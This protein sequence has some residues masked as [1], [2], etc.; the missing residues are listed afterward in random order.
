[1]LARP[2]EIVSNRHRFRG[3]N[4]TNPDGADRHR[5]NGILGKAKK[6]PTARCV[7]HLSSPLSGGSPRCL[8]GV[9]QPSHSVRNQIDS[10]QESERPDADG[11]EAE[12]D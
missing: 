8:K 11:R 3:P 12:H 5:S 7:H 10:Q 1:L 2:A 4:E 6:S 9:E